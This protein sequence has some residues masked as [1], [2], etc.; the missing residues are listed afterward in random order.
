MKVRSSAH[1][2]TEVKR[3]QA[4]FPGFF[5]LMQDIAEISS[6]ERSAEAAE[7]AKESAEAALAVAN[8][9][10]SVATT[11]AKQVLSDA[12]TKAA[13]L[14][15]QAET[16]SAAKRA[17]GE[18]VLSEAREQVQGYLQSETDAANAKAKEIV[19]TAENA[20]SAIM[21]RKKKATS[22][23]AAV[24]AALAAAQEKL[25]SENTKIA[26]IAQHKADL[27]AKLG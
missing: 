15:A 8:K 27:M 17:M 20:A 5:S 21:S 25:A 14:L 18:A 12:E 26:E 9:N 16:D 3:L 10:L 6:I 4:M 23:L 1:V 24:E 11:K 19:L 13:A 7:R 2:L 22:D